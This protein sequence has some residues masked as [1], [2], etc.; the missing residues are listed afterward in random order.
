MRQTEST[1]DLNR[2]RG[3]CDGGQYHVTRNFAGELHLP[4]M[5]HASCHVI[6]TPT[7]GDFI[8]IPKAQ[9]PSVLPQPPVPADDMHPHLHTKDNKSRYLSDFPV[10][11]TPTNPILQTARPS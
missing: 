2:D 4:R 1:R 6:L 5:L 7:S 3:K 9:T 11:H 10:V 8:S